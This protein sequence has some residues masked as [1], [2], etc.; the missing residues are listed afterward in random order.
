M[1]KIGRLGRYLEVIEKLSI[2]R[3]TI[4][5][6]E[7]AALVGA[8]PST[9]RQD[10]HT[11]LDKK[12]KSRVGYEV[13]LLR[14]TLL[15][16]LGMDKENHVVVLGSGKL[17]RALAG[18]REFGR[19]NIRFRAFFDNAGDKV[20]KEVDGAPVYHIS[21]LKDFLRIHTEVKLAIVAVP[22]ETAQEVASF[23]EDCGIEAFWNFS[24]VL[25]EF[26][27][28]VVV[29]NEYIGESLYHLIYQ[30]KNR[31][32]KGD[33]NM[34]LMIC[35]GSSCHLKGSEDVVK[36]LKQLMEKENLNR[37]VTLKGS[38]CMGNCS[39]SGVTVHWGDDLF[40][41]TPEDAQEFFYKTLL[42]SLKLAG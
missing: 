32:M 5:S 31:E 10:F 8:T 14:S 28:D 42:P 33:S 41:T 39:D 24:P 21:K 15:K 29:R 2:D 7:L 35:V 37:N 40:K 25:L 12:G 22:A 16:L 38:F 19:R 3:A 18:Y 23:A 13:A 6:Q 30:M 36:I 20:G 27:G 26:K 9:V 34:E 1:S 4:S 11:H 17:G